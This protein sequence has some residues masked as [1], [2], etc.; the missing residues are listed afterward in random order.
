MPTSTTT[1][2]WSLRKDA[3]ATAARSSTCVDSSISR[4]AHLH[5]NHIQVATLLMND[6]LCQMNHAKLGD[7]DDWAISFGF[8]I[9]A[10]VSFQIQVSHRRTAITGC[11]GSFG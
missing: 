11:G 7:A 3:A 4:G 2:L 6:D 8:R 1:E 5:A 9:L 10:H